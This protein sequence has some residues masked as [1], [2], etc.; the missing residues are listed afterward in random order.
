MPGLFW[1]S[2]SPQTLLA[3]ELSAASL[4]ADAI[5]VG[6]AVP[7]APQSWASFLSSVPHTEQACSSFSASAPSPVVERRYL[8]L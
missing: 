3:A 4:G 8:G 6:N 1:K 5:V 7:H 2:H